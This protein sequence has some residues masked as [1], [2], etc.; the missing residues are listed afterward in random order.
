[1]DRPG[2]A[3]IR[4]ASRALGSGSAGRSDRA[5]PAIALR[6][7]NIGKWDNEA[8]KQ[9]TREFHAEALPYIRVYDANGKFIGAVTGGMWDEV[10]AAFEKAGVRR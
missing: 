9:A 6:R 4:T 3:W 8:A 5:L 2:L 10:L 1:M 7:V